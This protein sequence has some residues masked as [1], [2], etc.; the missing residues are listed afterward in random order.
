MIGK[1]RR[2]YERER[3]NE[4]AEDERIQYG[5]LTDRVKRRQAALRDQ[6][7]GALNR[8]ASY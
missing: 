8:N 7:H 4:K 3:A 6:I 5:N 1:D 2:D